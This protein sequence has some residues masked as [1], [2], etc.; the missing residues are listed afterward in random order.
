MIG[1]FLEGIGKAV[2]PAV[3]VVHDT[4]GGDQTPVSSTN[5]EGW[6]K[7]E[8]LNICY[9]TVM[10]YVGGT[11]VLGTVLGTLLCKFLPKMGKK[12]TSTRRR[13]KA[14]TTRRRTYRKRK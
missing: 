13:R 4:L 3:G 1:K 8:N 5:V 6:E 14:T 2:F 7:D 12:R 10:F 11:L 9:R